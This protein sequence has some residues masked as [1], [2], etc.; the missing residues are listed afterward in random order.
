MIYW[1][2]ENWIEVF[3]AVAGILYIYLSIKQNILLWPFGLVT[4]LVYIY[5]FFVA[6]FYADMSLQFYYVFISIYGW[7]LWKKSEKNTEEESLKVSRIRLKLAIILFLI[8]LGIFAVIAW[9]LVN[10]TDSPMPYWDAL[11]TA[12]SITATWMLAKKIIEHWYIWVVVNLISIGLYFVR[13]LYPT[14]ILFTIY[15]VMAVIG[16]LQWKKSLVNIKENN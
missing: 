13:E 14:V 16:Y 3:G 10:Y 6:K 9:I 4:S 11:T 5:V 8:T 15:A 1:I 12:A 7:L 2:L